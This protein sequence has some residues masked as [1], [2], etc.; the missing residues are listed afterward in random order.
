MTVRWHVWVGVVLA[1][2]VRPSLWFVALRQSWRLARADWW[3]H[4]PF[5]PVP[6]RGVVEFRLATAYGLDG[7]ASVDDVIRYLRWCAGR[8]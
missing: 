6:D 7:H 3:R 2:V 8:R 4:P 5:L 1:V